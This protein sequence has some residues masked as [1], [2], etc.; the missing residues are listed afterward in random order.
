MKKLLLIVLIFL[1]MGAVCAHD[2]A[3]GTAGSVLGDTEYTSSIDDDGKTLEVGEGDYI[4]IGVDVDQSYSLNV[5]MDRKES[6][7]N[8]DMN[9]VSHDRI[10]IPTSVVSGDDEVP[11]GLGRHSIIYEF[12]FTNTTSVYRPNAFV[13]DSV[14][15][16][17]FEFIRTTK[18]PQNATYRFTSQFNIIKGNEP[19]SQ[20]LDLGDVNITRSDSLSFAL[21]GLNFVSVDVYLDG[22]FFDSFE[23]DENPFEDE[24]DTTKLAIGSYNLVF[25]VET[26]KV[27]GEY[28]VEAD[29]SKSTVSIKFDKSLI[30]TAQNKY[31]T[32]INATLNVCEIPDLNEIYV[33]APPVEVTYTRSVPIRFGGDD[34]G[35]LTVY[36]DGEKVY[37]SSILLTW[38]NTLYIPTKD[39]NGNYF[40]KG[41]HDLTFEFTFSDKYATFKPE[42]TEYNNALTFDF[43]DSQATSSFVNDKYVIRSNLTITDN[44]AQFIP[45]TSDA[46]VTIVHT[47]DIKLKIDDLQGIY[48]LT[49]F[50]DDV[51]IFDEYT[52]LNEIGVKTF[53]ARSS[54]EEVNERDIKVGTHTLR[55]EF[56]ALYECDVDVE[57]KNGVLNFKFTQKD[58]TVHNDGIRYQFNTTLKVT[59]K[60][61]TVHIVGVRNHTYFDDT[62]FIVM[63]NL[64]EI[65]DDDDDDDD[66][67]DEP[68]PVGTQ[69]VGIIVSDDNGVV[70]T[71]DYLMNVYDV[72]EW[73]YEF[74]NEMLSKAGTYTM[75]I[76]NLADNTY[77]TAR[78]TVKKADRSFNRKYSSNDFSVLFTLDFSSCRSDL[79]SPCTIE[80]DGQ[81]KTINVKKGSSG[82]KRE[83]LF[84]D[85]DPGTYTATFTLKGNEIYND[86]VLKSKVTVKKEDPTVRYHTTGSNSLV[87]EIDIGKSK[88]GADL[89]VSAGGLVKKFNV[90][91]NTERLTVD[92]SELGSGT[93]DV[94]IDFAGNARYNS[95]TLKG[96]IEITHQPEPQVPHNDPQTDEERNNA[97]DGGGNDDGGTGTGTGNANVAGSGNGTY[98]GQISFNGKGF[99]GNLGTQGSGS[100][101]GEGPK[102]YEITENAVK[103]IDDN[104]YVFLII[105]IAAIAIWIL[106]FIYERRDNDEE[107]Y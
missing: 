101:N 105:I 47:D 45:I 64:Y 69:D 65:N 5:Y 63:M 82:S 91:R 70:Y 84:D 85:V 60:Q 32:T 4:P 27:R 103:K 36:I 43:L 86:A 104:S 100:G 8:E 55:F 9:N 16:F 74:E 83:V 87:V 61:K 39:S 93:Y 79:N 59:E 6:T 81:K 96:A 102:G 44:A 78:F 19:I 25:I 22:E 106:G 40:D 58:S 11:L 18:N 76:I 77:D 21:R 92:L 107:E 37:D 13:S 34:A 53:L 62:E 67:D 2:D 14:V 88:T 26:G 1:L 30:T 51:E 57:F 54:I 35:N 12:K 7:I 10:D 33:D 90:D 38:E 97:G 3:N 24:I 49:V 72:R 99:D 56:Q 73:N 52:G 41:V 42:V 29:G 17:D 95:K 98:N 48:N 50:V 46:S 80:L 94:D 75:K 20:T 66:D 71:G 15:Y 89:T 23:T 68:L 28:T 31:I